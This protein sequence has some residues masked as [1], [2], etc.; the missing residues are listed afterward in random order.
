M[1]WSMHCPSPAP[2]TTTHP[3]PTHWSTTA[4]APDRT[5]E[6]PAFHRRA[7][8]VC[9][10]F[11]ATQSRKKKRRVYFA[12]KVASTAK[13]TW[14]EHAKTF[15]DKKAWTETFSTKLEYLTL[16]L[17]RNFDGNT[18]ATGCRSVS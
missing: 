17:W 8:P 7:P 2:R 16:R 15:K 10:L 18:S 5:V 3:K 11:L 12:C 1:R 14:A 9:L 6:R 4:T 13:K